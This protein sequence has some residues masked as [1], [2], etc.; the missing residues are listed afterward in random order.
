MV[1]LFVIIFI[2]SLFFKRWGNII[3]IQKKNHVDFKYVYLQIILWKKEK[4]NLQDM[5]VVQMY[6]IMKIQFHFQSNYW[7][8][9][10]F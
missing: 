1:Y 8:F 3:Y 10:F 2:D 7:M 6:E 5:I 4:E 9:W